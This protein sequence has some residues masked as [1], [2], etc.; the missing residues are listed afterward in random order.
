M[1]VTMSL[2]RQC[3]GPFRQTLPGDGKGGTFAKMELGRGITNKRKNT[4]MAG[5][6]DP[7]EIS[8]ELGTPTLGESLMGD[9]PVEFP[10]AI[11]DPDSYARGIDRW[12]EY[13]SQDA[14]PQAWLTFF[15]NAQCGLSRI[16]HAI[17]RF[18][19]WIGQ[20]GSTNPTSGKPRMRPPPIPIDSGAS[21]TGVGRKWMTQW[22]KGAALA[23]ANSSRSFR[24]GE[25]IGRQILGTCALPITIY[26]RRT[27]QPK[28]IGNHVVADAVMAEGP[29]LMSKRTLVATQGQLNFTTSVLSIEDNVAIQLT[30]LPSGHHNL[31][32]T[33]NSHALSQS[34]SMTSESLTNPC[35]YP[36]L[37]LYPLLKE[38]WLTPMSAAGLNEVHLQHSHCGSHTLE[39]CCEPGAAL[40]IMT[41][42]NLPWGNAP[43]EAPRTG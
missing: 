2:W 27:N 18:D 39:I 41:K 43:V 29:L 1:R 21:G 35:S 31:P 25:G 33:F 38:L 13:Y 7:Q 30:N 23:L 8:E 36:A 9:G 20:A 10:G 37:K 28:A 4:Y 22:T 14:T 11:V 17:H 5:G 19:I 24:F 6:D 16:D 26:P 12:A 34:Q 42:S 32:G 40:L 15:A 3:P